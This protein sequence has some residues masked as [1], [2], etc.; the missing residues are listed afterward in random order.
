M[1]LQIVARGIWLY[2]GT[3]ETPVDV[4]ALDYDWHYELGKAD[5]QLEP[6]EE[7]ERADHAGLLYYA[8]FR[9]ALNLSEPTWVDSP[10]CQTIEEAMQCAESK[11]VGGIRWSAPPA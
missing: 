2:G 10:A 11:V 8:R 5:G 7:P 9:Y 1:A 6:G 3:V 4:V